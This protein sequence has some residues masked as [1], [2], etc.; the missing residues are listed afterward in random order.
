MPI[1]LTERLS[2]V[3]LQGFKIGSFLSDLFGEGRPITIFTV[4]LA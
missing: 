4:K 2:H 1:F 3:M